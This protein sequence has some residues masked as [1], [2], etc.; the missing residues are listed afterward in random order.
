MSLA[1]IASV[2]FLSMLGA[3]S[4]W[5]KSTLAK[6]A[7]PAPAQQ[8]IVRAQKTQALPESVLN[9]LAKKKI[10]ADELGIYVHDVNA[11]APLLAHKADTL[12]NPASTLKLVTTWAA[13]KKLGPAW[14]WN[15]EAWA[16]G[17]VVDGVLYGDLILKG[18][19]DPFLVY[20][21]FWQFINEI[22]LKGIREI[23]GDLIV[24]NSFFDLP[25]LDPG[26]FDKRPYR[27]YNAPPSAL[28]FNFQ[29]TRFMFQPDSALQQVTVTTLP[30]LNAVA[31]ASQLNWAEGRC[32][33][34]HYRPAL[35]QLA[36]DDGSRTVTVSGDYA[37]SCGRREM[38]RVVSSPEQHAFDAFKQ[39]WTELGGYLGGGLRT[40]SVQASDQRLHVHS[41]R[42]LGE[43]IR[44][45]N[46]WSN[47]VMTRQLLLTLGAEAYASPGTLAKGRMAILDVLRA[48][49]VTTAGIII[50]NG[51]GL[52]RKAR[53][54]ARQLG[55][56]LQAVWHEPYMP[57]LLNSLPLLGEDGTL[58]RRL[59]D[60]AMQGRSRLKTGTL[61]GVTALAGY[62]LTR[63]GK[64]LVV[65]MLHNG[66]KAGSHGQAIQNKVLEW[67]F[68]Q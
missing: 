28:M 60:S 52:S 35:Q 45:I 66:R 20:E 64:R 30:K 63:S 68:E 32:R 18:Y 29:A 49:G 48:Q 13:L 37:Q 22:R 31:V 2:V 61:N 57:E 1:V 39:I 3:D 42:T 34:Q 5:A 50:D 38:M 51:S 7:P 47:N 25:V 54:S 6:S 67:L 11:D 65:V 21:T 10:A 43:Q 53:L 15:T 9:Y 16:R 55:V 62:M 27:V 26:A 41:S 12:R 23:S 44:L 14:R 40:G 58:V 17:E 24:D 8:I 36:H 4:V 33:R 46:K 19:G 59:H 56:L